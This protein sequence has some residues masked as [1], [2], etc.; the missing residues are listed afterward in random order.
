MQ[1]LL[2]GG[3]VPKHCTLQIKM[4]QAVTIATTHCYCIKCITFQSVALYTLR[5]LSLRKPADR[6]GWKCTGWQST[7]TLK[8]TLLKVAIYST[9]NITTLLHSRNTGQSEVSPSWF[10]YVNSHIYS[11]HNITAIIIYKHMHTWVY[12]HNFTIHYTRC[13]SITIKLLM[14]LY[15]IWLLVKV[16]RRCMHCCKTIW[17]EN[18]WHTHTHTHNTGRS[19][20]LDS[21]QVKIFARVAREKFW[22]SW[23]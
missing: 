13:T 22:E 8:R 2:S 20:G 1:I 6:D 5:T 16:C 11:F 15:K 3:A 10:Y 17:L 12:N 18:K 14:N 23:N 21:G 4:K 19:Y 9:W 7:C